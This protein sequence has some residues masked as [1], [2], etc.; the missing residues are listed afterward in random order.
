VGDYWFT[1]EFY[2]LIHLRKIPLLPIPRSLEVRVVMQDI[3]INGVPATPENAVPEPALPGTLPDEGEM[4]DFWVSPEAHEDSLAVYWEKI[5]KSWEGTVTP[6][7]A[8]V[9]L[10]VAKLDSLSEAG[11]AELA[12]LEQGGRWRL[13]PSLTPP[14]F[15]RAQGWAMFAGVSARKTGPLPPRMYV[16]AGYGFGNHR[17]LGTAE[18][19]VP[20]IRSRWNLSDGKGRGSHYKLLAL[21]L[22]GVK[23]G[24][25]FAGDGRRYTRSASAFFYGND[26]NHYYENRGGAGRVTV[27]PARRLDLYVGAGYYENRILEQRTG[28]NVLGRRLRP[29]GN[30]RAAA[31]DERRLFAGG[32]WGLGPLDLAGFV[33]WHR[34]R[35]ADF[36]QVKLSGRLDLMDR[37]GNQWLLQGGVREF[38]RQA[39]LQWK[40]WMGDYGT[41]RGYP[42]GVLTGDGG[43]WASLDLRL[44]W[45]MWRALKVPLLK[46]LGLQPIGFADYG[47]TWSKPGENAVGPEEGARDWRADVGF[48]FGRRFDLPGL[49]EFNKFRMYAATPVGN[50]RQG[51]G[52]RFLVAFEK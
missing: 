24:A 13:G 46:G 12:D 40:T 11:A 51:R 36:R 48:G 30:H 39:P 28:W 6:E 38:D 17:W 52:W 34:V 49:G 22:Q 21:N 37:S 27:K 16:A 3:E 44:G 5:E 8:P 25:Q 29:D 42:A 47:H 4:G 10:D 15:N 1:T 7:L 50:G 43:S 9:T 20:L 45:D 19:E 32:S 33:A 35:H 41:L 26:P 18:F 31:L 14:Q 2:G 23:M